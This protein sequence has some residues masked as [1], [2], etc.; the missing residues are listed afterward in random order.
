MM[1]M[2]GGAR[3]SALIDR[4]EGV[5]VEFK[6][7]LRWD[8]RTAQVNK[9][10]TRVAVKTI[11]GFMNSD[12]GSLLLGVED[13]GSIRGLDADL[14]TLNKKSLDGL[15]LLIRESVAAH[16]GADIDSAVDIEFAVFDGLTV[17]VVDCRPHAAPVFLT[18]DGKRELWIRSG[19]LTR[20]LD[21]AAAIG[22]VRRRWPEPN[23]FSDE[24]LRTII[25][26]TVA[27]AT[28]R[29]DPKVGSEE[30]PYW[31]K[32]STR[33]VLDLF[34]SNLNR[35]PG[36]KRMQIVSPW[37]S[38]INGP[39]ASLTL[40]RILR[41]LREEDTTVYVVTRPPEHEWHERAVQRLADTRRA[42]IALLPDLHVKLFTA[43]TT[44]SSFAMFGSAN[45]TTRSLTNRE[46]GVLVSASGDGKALV[47][48][49][50][51]EAAEI[52]R[53][54]D[55]KLLCKARL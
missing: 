10:L 13:D 16:L 44:E 40:D 2:D 49:L 42:N 34:L 17:A 26:E 21:T 43:Q 20:S 36:W 33:R 29:D 9:E 3:I 37:I 32:L 22:Y 11:A 27:R 1:A 39:H 35:S 51:Y 24:R 53:H 5:H 19:N 38:D 54:P 4:G 48:E 46:I 18:R 31:L 30:V 23:P 52:Y 47:R 15:E 45:F 7:S 41:R 14:A 28:G 8:Y 12:G 25:D 50:E 6:A 55:R